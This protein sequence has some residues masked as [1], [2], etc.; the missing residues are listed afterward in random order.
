MCSFVKREELHYT[1]QR[2]VMKITAVVSNSVEGFPPASHFILSDSTNS[3]HKVAI[4]RTLTEGNRV[5]SRKAQTLMLFNLYSRCV[6]MNIAYGHLFHYCNC[7]KED[8]SLGGRITLKLSFEKYG[9]VTLS[10]LI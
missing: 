3:Q 7:L 4:T 5:I 2:I 8:L 10:G 9:A 6:R 1:P